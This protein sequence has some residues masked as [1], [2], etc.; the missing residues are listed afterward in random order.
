MAVSR[1]SPVYHLCMTN[2]DSDTF[3]SPEHPL[4]ANSVRQEATER[5]ADA[6]MASF[7]PAG[8]HYRADAKLD[9]M[10]RH[11][12]TV[13]LADIKPVVRAPGVVGFDPKRSRDILDAI[14]SGTPLP[15]IMVTHEAGSAFR[16]SLYDGF[17]RFGLSV[18]L[19]FTHIAAV[20]V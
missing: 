3:Y 8:T 19:G 9:P 5:I 12:F 16:Y 11:M 17:H 14:R 1:L 18:V 2:P 6:G 10:R 4:I 7:V 15:P 13:A 20:V